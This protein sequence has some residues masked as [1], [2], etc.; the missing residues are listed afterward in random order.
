VIAIPISQ[1]ASITTLRR[2]RISCSHCGSRDIYRTQPRG[3]IERHIH[4]VF[5][6]APFWCAACDRR[7]YVHMKSSNA[8]EKALRPQKLQP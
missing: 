2:S 7:F 8:K 1:P 5:H 4:H 3:L 6:F